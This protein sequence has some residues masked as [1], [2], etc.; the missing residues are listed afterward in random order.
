MKLIQPYSEYK[1]TSHG[2]PVMGK[3]SAKLFAMIFKMEL[4]RL[5]TYLGKF[6]AHNALGLKNCMTKTP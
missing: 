5:W 3:L 4:Q 1:K 2:T 6:L